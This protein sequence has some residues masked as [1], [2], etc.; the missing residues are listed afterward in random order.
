[1]QLLAA[2]ALAYTTK[3]IGVAE[4]LEL[5]DACMLGDR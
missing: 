1:V 5:L 3:P 2:G 4:L